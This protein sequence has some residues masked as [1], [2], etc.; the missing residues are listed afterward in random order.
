VKKFFA[1]LMAFWMV[2]GGAVPA[3]FSS[4]DEG[5]SLAPQGTQY[6]FF[7]EH[8]HGYPL[9]TSSAALFLTYETAYFLRISGRRLPWYGVEIDLSEIYAVDL[10]ANTYTV[11]F[12]GFVPGGSG[13]FAELEEP[14][15]GEPW[16]NRF[17][18]NSAVTG[19]DFRITLPEIN[20]GFFAAQA[21][22]N[23]FSGGTARRIRM[24]C[25]GDYPHTATEE[26]V[27]R[28]IIVERDGEVAWSLQGDVL[29]HFSPGEITPIWAIHNFGGF[30][31]AASEA[32]R[33]EIIEYRHEVY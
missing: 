26:F 24:R 7:Y 32:M 20:E 13:G 6:G 10:S 12:D 4:Y 16:A 22:G 18:F 9:V 2:L 30:R 21:H 3:N 28:D 8:A 5:S 1:F 29:P 15:D 27:L 31:I 33:M 19:G 11:I 17:G 14:L 23:R 25:T